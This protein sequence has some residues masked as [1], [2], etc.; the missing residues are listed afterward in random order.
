LRVL[1]TRQQI[2]PPLFLEGIADFLSSRIVD[3]ESSKLLGATFVG[4]GVA[5]LLHASTVAVVGGLTLEQL[6]H[7]IPSFPTM[8]EV[9]LNLLDAA[10]L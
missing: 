5:E 1:S 6:S 2:F 3:E 10:G 9:Y 7:A 4:S 8:S